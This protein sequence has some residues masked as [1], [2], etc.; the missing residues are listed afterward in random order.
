MET[1]E[2]Q[3]GQRLLDRARARSRPLDRVVRAVAHYREREGST[4]A[5]AVTYYAFLSFFPELALAFAAVGFI[6]AYMPHARTELVEGLQLLLPGMIGTGPGQLSLATLEAAA[7]P[8]AGIGSLAVLYSGLSWITSMRSALQSMFDTPKADQPGLVRAYAR[9]FVM[10]VVIGVVLVVSVGLAGIV[11]AASWRIGDALGLG[12]G[13]TWLIT[14]SSVALGIVANVVLCVAMFRLLGEPQFSD[15][16]V[17]RGAL[18]GALGFEALKQASTWLL[19]ST[20]S[21]PA[22]QA[23]GIALILLVWIYYFSRVVMF[24]AAWVATSEQ[25]HP[26]QTHPG[27]L[28]PRHRSTLPGK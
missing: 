20:S 10:L 12:E 23:F 28:T 19:A 15:V 24:A 22:F 17:R 4:L 26:E 16:A 13:L 1:Q 3:R 11:T 5:A 27:Q 21:Q 25:T 8:V 14:G 9:D 7:G 2:Q 18:L 6:S